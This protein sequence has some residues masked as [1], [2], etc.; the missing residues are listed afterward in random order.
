[1]R[2][3]IGLPLEQ[4]KVRMRVLLLLVPVWLMLLVVLLVGAWWLKF[5]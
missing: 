1:V 2:L 3:R 5:G 4:K